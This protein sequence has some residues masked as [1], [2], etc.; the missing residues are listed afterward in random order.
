MSAA[1][2]FF[3]PKG[4][5]QL[6]VAPVL[7]F[8]LTGERWWGMMWS[9]REM[10]TLKLFIVASGSTNWGPGM[11]KKLLW[12]MERAVIIHSAI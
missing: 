10:V 6:Y 2:W 8:F 3:A 5:N 7:F 1:A 4:E 9:F 11:I 12:R